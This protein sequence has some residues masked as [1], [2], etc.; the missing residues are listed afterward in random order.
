VVGFEVVV[1]AAEPVELI[2]A[3]V[4]GVGP[5]VSV[6]DLG[7]LVVAMVVEAPG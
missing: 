3:G 1:V 6:V 2:E 5:G 4:V 7:P